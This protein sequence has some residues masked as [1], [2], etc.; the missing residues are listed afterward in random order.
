MIEAG[1]TAEE[2][3]SAVDRVYLEEEQRIEAEQRYLDWLH[4][5]DPTRGKLASNKQWQEPT[6]Q[7][8]DYFEP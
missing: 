8:P 3:E 1:Y 7:P 6:R 2:A 5:F 4:G